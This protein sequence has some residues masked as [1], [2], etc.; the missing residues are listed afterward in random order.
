LTRLFGLEE[1]IPYLV[2]TGDKLNHIVVLFFTEHFE[3]SFRE[4]QT[5]SYSNIVVDNL[6]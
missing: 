5:V 2:I 4:V 6:T 3:Y 1:R